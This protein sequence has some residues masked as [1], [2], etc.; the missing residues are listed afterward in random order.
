MQDPG[1]IGDVAIRASAYFQGQKEHM[2]PS[3]LPFR[4][5]LFMDPNAAFHGHGAKRT[6]HD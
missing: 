2:P 1:A 4:K 6:K 5:Q 3:S